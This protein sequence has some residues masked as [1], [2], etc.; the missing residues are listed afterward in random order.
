M[1]G[2]S[3]K[4]VVLSLSILA[5]GASAH[6]GEAR[7]FVVLGQDI[8]SIKSEVALEGGAAIR[9]FRHYQGFAAQMS[10]AA[11]DRIRQRLGSSVRIEEDPVVHAIGK[12]GAPAPQPAQT[13]PWG[14]SAVKSPEA[15]SVSR[16]AGVLVCVVDTG[17]QADHPDL[18][19]NVAGGVNFVVK[20]GR[21][22]S[23]AWGDDNGHG[24][25]VAGTIAALDNAI[26]VVGVAPEARLFAVKALDSRGSGYLSDVAD[27]IRS[28]VTAGAKVINMSLGS[29]A[30]STLLEDALAF[31]RNSGLF[32]VAAAGNESGPVSYPAKYNTVLAVSAVDSAM[33]FAYFS[34]SGPE[35]IFA[36]PGVAVLSTTYKS[37]YA[38]F[39]GTSM[40]SPHVAGVAALIIGAGSGG[41]GTDD[42]G[43]ASEQQG[44]GFINALKSVLM[45]IEPKG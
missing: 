44:A 16:G 21:L 15:W 2:I 14:I 5:A 30:G 45:P 18:Q 31:S 42:I 12:P 27:G 41:F 39:N 26:G 9:D 33:N 10:D 4:A 1:S 32:N 8:A 25:H 22:D 36:A 37:S 34:N 24:T 35:I 38:T 7:R 20:R 3:K 40:A 19:S 29:S 43:L 6:A 13:I 11:A 17:I 28:C 23:A